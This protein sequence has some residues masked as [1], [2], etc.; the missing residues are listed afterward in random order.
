MLAIVMEYD[1]KYYLSTSHNEVYTTIYLD[2]DGFCF[3]NERWFAFTSI[4]LQWWINELVNLRY[5]E[6][7]A[8][9]LYF[10][11]GPFRMD[12]FKDDNMGLLIKCINS[13]GV[14]EIVELK[15]E[16]SYVEFL[17]V[18]LK[19]TQDI[20]YI[21]HF[22]YPDKQAERSFQ[23]VFSRYAKTLRKIISD[24]ERQT[25]GTLRTI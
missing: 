2:V 13:R 15:I 8:S 21:L 25:L 1:N 16:Y 9:K 17:K 24:C 12:V 4:I 5:S 3:P 7:H 11:D 18:L 19:A 22:T 14:N 10:V 23:P 20:L 6:N